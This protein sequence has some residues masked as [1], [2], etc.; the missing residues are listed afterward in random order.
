MKKQD[1][2]ALLYHFEPEREAAVK[3]ALKKCKI[4][5]RRIPD[6]DIE[7]KVGYL[8]G[9][10]GFKRI[11]TS[12]G[13]PFNEEVLILQNVQGRLLDLL[14]RQFREDEIEPVKLKAVVTPF[15]SLWSLRRLC[16]TIKKEHGLL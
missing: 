1:A 6:G 11:D 13:V 7:Q 15:N 3:Q 12:D 10:K 8:A 2:L 4:A 5:V 9:L 14:L 16:D